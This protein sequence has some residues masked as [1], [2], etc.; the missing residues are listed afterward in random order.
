[1]KRLG[2]P[3]NNAHISPVYEIQTPIE[4]EMNNSSCPRPCHGKTRLTPGPRPAF[5]WGNVVW[6]VLGW[7][8]TC[9]PFC[10]PAFYFI[11]ILFLFYVYFIPILFLFCYVLYC[12]FFFFS[13]FF[14][15][16]LFFFPSPLFLSLLLILFF[17]I[18]FHFIILFFKGHLPGLWVISCS[19]SH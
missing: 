2:L 8:G 7:L 15:L 17:L 6:S 9:L 11:P 13:I 3:S 10:L 12:I 18:L 1:M 16:F 5:T 4:K 14:F 19:G